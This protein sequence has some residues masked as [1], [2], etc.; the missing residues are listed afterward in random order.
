MGSKDALA[1]ELEVASL[2]VARD[3]LDASEL[4]ANGGKF[5]AARSHD[6]L[7]Y[8]STVQAWAYHLVVLE[9]ATLEWKNASHRIYIQEDALRDHPL[10]QLM[11]TVIDP[12]F[13][14]IARVVAAD[15]Q[16]R[17]FKGKRSTILGNLLEETNPPP[18]VLSCL[19]HAKNDGFYARRRA[20]RVHRPSEVTERDVTGLHLWVKRRLSLMRDLIGIE[21]ESSVKEHIAFHIG[22]MA[23]KGLRIDKAVL[24]Q[25]RQAEA[26]AG[27]RISDYSD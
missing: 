19:N 7:A 23:E 27:K 6:I 11:I 5:G 16:F 3:H 20:G 26:R 8:E 25:L 13:R 14:G 4:L 18:T 10:K 24:F 21:L 2:E 1:P 17:E 9:W 22:Q 15:A 12:V